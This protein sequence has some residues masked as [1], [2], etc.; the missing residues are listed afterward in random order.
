MKVKTYTLLRDKIEE[1]I[2]GG[3]NKCEK[4]DYLTVSL[5]DTNEAFEAATYEILNYVINS[6]SE[7]FDWSDEDVDD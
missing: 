5:L 7:Y 6:V 2:R 1:G 4:R 3:L